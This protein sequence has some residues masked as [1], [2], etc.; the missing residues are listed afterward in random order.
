MWTR[1]SPDAHRL[2]AIFAGFQLHALTVW[3]VFIGKI[4]AQFFLSNFTT[5][6]AKNRLVDTPMLA[7][8]VQRVLASPE[9]RD[10]E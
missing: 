3:R 1:W 7:L 6:F 9:W 4:R 8:T 10:C 5:Q 2:A